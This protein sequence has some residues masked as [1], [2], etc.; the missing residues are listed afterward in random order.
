MRELRAAGHA[1]RVARRQLRHRV[2]GYCSSCLLGS[3]KITQGNSLAYPESCCHAHSQGVIEG[4]LL[5]SLGMCPHSCYGCLHTQALQLF[6]VQGGLQASM[7]AADHTAI[8]ALFN[9]P[10][11]M[12][13]HQGI[14]SMRYTHTLCVSTS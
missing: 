3:D 13:G 5:H 2:A 11:L 14:Q 1:S 9:K 4:L 7:G 8:G 6:W 12:I 10:K